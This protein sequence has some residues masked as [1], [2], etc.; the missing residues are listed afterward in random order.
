MES[1]DVVVVGGS[2]AGSIAGKY[3]SEAGMR[4][5]IVEAAKAPREKPCSGIQFSYFEKLMG[6]KIP[7]EKL[8]QN[9]LKSLYMEFP[10][11]KSFKVKFKMLNFTRDV[12]DNWLNEVAIESGAEFRGGVRC[13]DIK[14]S[15]G[16]YI[17]TLKP[18]HQDVEQVSTKYLVAADGLSSSIRK[19]IKPEDFSKKPL[20]PTMNY[21]LKTKGDGDLDPHTLYQFWNLDYNNLM[22]AWTYKKNDLWVVGTGHTDNLIE[23]CD[24]LLNYVKT[25]FKLEGEIVKREGYASTFKL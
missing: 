24:N 21:Y 13:N 18:K 11:E 2:I 19:K 25:K 17:I 14:K 8:C 23:R 3:L 15:N 10:D 20:A 9:Q 1:Y 5:L 22:F 4:T 16:S 6:L 12:L 7:K